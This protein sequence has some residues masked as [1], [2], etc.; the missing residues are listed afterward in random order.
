ML[1]RSGTYLMTSWKD[2][3]VFRFL[4]FLCVLAPSTVSCDKSL[5]FNIS[6]F[7]A[8]LPL[9]SRILSME[10]TDGCA[11]AR[12][13][14]RWELSRRD[15]RELYTHQRDAVDQLVERVDRGQR[16]N[17]IWIPVGMGKTLIVAAFIRSLI[18]SDRMPPYCVYSLPASA[19]DNILREMQ[20]SGYSVH[21]VEYK[22]GRAHV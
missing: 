20:R 8:W 11:F 3:V 22:I 1:F 10:S 19:H 17:L 15:D 4:V 9:R 13:E 7:R 5:K 16:G 14:S 6:D 12:V 21:H 18:E 2:T